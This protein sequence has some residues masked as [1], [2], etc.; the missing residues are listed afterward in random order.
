MRAMDVR[1][2]AGPAHHPEGEQSEPSLG[3]VNIGPVVVTP[4]PGVQEWSGEID[5]R[6]ARDEVVSLHGRVD[7]RTGVAEWTITPV[8]EGE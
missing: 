3:P 5:L 4:P 1:R 2:I 6:P 8:L 7:P